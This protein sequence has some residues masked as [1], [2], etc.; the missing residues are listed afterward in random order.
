MHDAQTHS[1]GC[2]SALF[3][4][5]A[6]TRSKCRWTPV[7]LC[8]NVRDSRNPRHHPRSRGHPLR[9]RF[10]RWND[11]T[12]AAARAK[13]A[14]RTRRAQRALAESTILQTSFACAG[15]TG[16]LFAMQFFSPPSRC[17]P[18]MTSESSV[19]D[20]SRNRGRR[21]LSTEGSR[22]AAEKHNVNLNDVAARVILKAHRCQHCLG[23]LLAAKSACSPLGEMLSAERP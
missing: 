13:A 9:L 8:S 14:Q 17:S 2:A 5:N 15:S 16:V 22:E 21:T 7:F 6:P 12:N 20:F 4:A 11:P 3:V 10:R 18:G 19:S 1:A 23:A